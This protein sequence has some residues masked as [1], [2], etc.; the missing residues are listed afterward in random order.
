MVRGAS[1]AALVAVAVA[2]LATGCGQ[3]SN[4]NGQGATTSAAP[5][6]PASGSASATPTGSTA[7]PVLPDSCGSVLSLDDLDTALGHPLL[8]RTVYIKGQAEPKINRTGRVTCRYGVRKVGNKTVVPL[9][10]GISAYADAGSAQSRLAFTVDDQRSQ[11]AAPT[12]VTLGEA[13][14]TAL[15]LPAS[16][17]LIL[18]KGSTTV[19]ISIT[20]DVA[21]GNAARDMLTKLGTVVVSH[22]P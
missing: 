11:G 4:G 9:E 19:A 2:V 6:G 22:L 12:D 20:R 5:S 7:P 13:K 15:V 3:K 14:G 1:L 10:V 17:L 18:G 8:G 16:A 21:A